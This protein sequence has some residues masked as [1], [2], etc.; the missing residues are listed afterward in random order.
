MAYNLQG[1]IR[2]TSTNITTE[3]TRLAYAS[4][5]VAN[6]NTN[7]YKAVRFEEIMDADGSVHGVERTDFSQGEFYMTKNPLDV[8]ID[9][10]GFIPVTTLSGEIRYTRDGSFMTNK[11][12][13]LITKNG[14]LVGSGIK[15]DAAA[16]KTEIRKNGDVYSY[17][18]LGEE[19]EYLGTIPVVQFQN[20]EGLKNSGG[21]NFIAT[22]EAGKMK[23]VENHDYIKQYGIERT[24]FDLT[25]EIYMISR[26]NASILA[27][28]KLMTAVNSMYQSAINITE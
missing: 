12:G 17:K 3:F 28:S 21:N 6:M 18:K 10:A 2:K 11:D 8:A 9:G 19:G 14:D 4:Q 7:G 22:E 15:I 27:S 5:N 1:I 24:N 16:E 26:I 20:P 25:N 13:Y 23:L